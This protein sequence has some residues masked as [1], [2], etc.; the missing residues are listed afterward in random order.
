MKISRA[1]QLIRN[2]SILVDHDIP[3]DHILHLAQLIYDETHKENK[4]LDSLV[5]LFP[6]PFSPPP[7]KKKKK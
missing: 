3:E 5:D 7:P 6:P 1:V 2:W 4:D